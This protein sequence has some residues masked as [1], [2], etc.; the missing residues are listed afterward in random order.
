MKSQEKT[1]RGV[2]E[3]PAGSGVWWVNYYAN[4][5]RHREKVGRKGDAIKLYQTRKADAL[6]GRKLPALRNTKQVTVSDLIDLALKAT[7]NHKDRRNYVSK[8]EIVRT[9]LGDRAASEVTPQE[10]ADWLES[11]FKT[12]ATSNRYKAFISLCYRQGMRNEKVSGNPAR[13]F[14][15]R[16]ESAGRI[17]Y[18]SREEYNRV[19]DAIRKLFPAHL[20][21]FVVSVNTG[22]RL[23]EQ[24]SAT[25]SQFDESRRAIDLTQTKNGTARTIHLNADALAAIESL[26]HTGQKPTDRIFARCGTKDRFDTRSWF[27]PCLEAAKITG[28]VWHCNRHTFCSWLAMAGATI[29]EIQELAGHKTITMSARYAHL[30][31]DHKLSVLDRITAIATENANSHQNS[32]QPKTAT[33]KKRAKAA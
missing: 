23:T 22:M 20:P 4:G 31:P 30:S 10:I 32:H 9:D 7:E 27:V 28:Y 5:Q 25:W 29:K 3:H 17:R 8:A 19:C 24:Y 15:K 13:L 14:S 12:P 16:R 1:V 18:L 11:R 21:E 33:R 6:A 26:R 2:Y